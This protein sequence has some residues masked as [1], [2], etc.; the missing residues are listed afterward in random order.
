[1][2][3]EDVETHVNTLFHDFPPDIKSIYLNLERQV[4]AALNGQDEHKPETIQAPPPPRSPSPPALQ[5]KK[6]K[7]KKKIPKDK[8]FLTPKLNVEFTVKTAPNHFDTTVLDR[9][10]K[11]PANISVPD[12]ALPQMTPPAAGW[13]APESE[14]VLTRIKSVRPKSALVHDQERLPPIQ[15]LEKEPEPSDLRPIKSQ[16]ISHRQKETPTERQ[17]ELSSVRE[18]RKARPK[19]A[20]VRHEQMEPKKKRPL[21]A[22]PKKRPVNTIDVEQFKHMPLEHFDDAQK[23]ETRS[24]EEWVRL[25]PSRGERGTPGSSRYHSVGNNPQEWKWAPCLVLDYDTNDH[26][27]LIEWPDGHQKHVTRFNLM[28]DEEDKNRYF[29]RIEA[30]NRTKAELIA[31]I[32]HE[33]TVLSREMV[34]EG[35][36]ADLEEMYDYSMKK[37]DYMLQQKKLDEPKRDPYMNIFMEQLQKPGSPVKVDEAIY[38][39]VIDSVREISTFLFTANGNLQTALFQVMGC[40]NAILP[41]EKQFF[42]SSF[43]R[44]IFFVDFMQRMTVDVETVQNIVTKLLSDFFDFEQSDYKQYNDS[45][46]QKFL[47]LLNAVMIAQTQ[48]MVEDA[49]VHFLGMFQIGVQKLENNNRASAQRFKLTEP[50]LR[51]I[52][53]ES[54][55]MI[56]ITLFDGKAEVQGSNDEIAQKLHIRGSNQI[57]IFPSIKKVTEDIKSLFGKPWRLTE[58]S[59]PHIESL[60]ME[61]LEQALELCLP[62]N[63]M[64]LYENGSRLIE[65]IIKAATPQIEAVFERYKR[66]EFIVKNDPL[67]V[68]NE[69]SLLEEFDGPVKLIHNARKAIQDISDNHVPFPPFVLDCSVIK[70]VYMTLTSSALSKIG[71]LLAK[72][73]ATAC[74]QMLSVYDDL[75]EKLRFDPGVNVDKWE[76]LEL[77]LMNSVIEFDTFNEQF[78][79]IQN[80]WQLMFDY[81]MPVPSEVDKLYWRTFKWPSWFA[82]EQDQSRKRLEASRTMITN[83]FGEDIKQI[84][85]LISKVKTSLDDLSLITDLSHEPIVSENLVPLAKMVTKVKDL[86]VNVR[87]ASKAMHMEMPVFEGLDDL[88]DTFPGY[89]MLW[90]LVKDTQRSLAQWIQEPFMEINAELIMEKLSVWN[91]EISTLSRSFE[92]T[93]GPRK[94]LA[95]LR[96]HVH[97]FSLNTKVITY[98]RS[99]A[100]RDR[101]WEKIQVVTGLTLNDFVGLRLHQILHLD[102]E[103]ISDILKDISKQAEREYA[104]EKLMEQ[105]KQDLVQK[106]FV[107]S[108]TLCSSYVAIQNGEFCLQ[109]IEDHII[110]AEQFYKKAEESDMKQKYDQWIGQLNKGYDLVRRWMQLQTVF[111]QLYPVFLNES[112]WPLLGQD[113]VD[114][115]QSIEKSMSV[116]SNVLTKNKKFITV[117]HRSDLIEL[118]KGSSTRMDRLVDRTKSLLTAKRDSYPRLYFLNDEKVLEIVSS[119]T[120]AQ[121]S[122]HISLIFEHVASLIEVSLEDNVNGINRIRGTLERGLSSMQSKKTEEPIRRK[123]AEEKKRKN[124]SAKKERRPSSSMDGSYSD[125]PSRRSSRRGSSFSLGR[126][127]LAVSATDTETDDSSG[128]PSV[129]ERRLS[130]KF[131]AG[132]LERKTSAP[133]VSAVGSDY[134]TGYQ[135]DSSKNSSFKGMN[136]RWSKV[137]G[138]SFMLKRGIGPQKTSEERKKEEDE[139]HP[140]QE[141]DARLAYVGRE[142]R[143]MEGDSFSFQINYPIGA[144]VELLFKAIQDEIKSTLWDLCRRCCTQFPRES[145]YNTVLKC[146]K[147]FNLQIGMIAAHVRWVEEM[148]IACASGPSAVKQCKSK[149]L[150][151][152]DALIAFTKTSITMSVRHKME[153]LISHLNTLIDMLLGDHEHPTIVKYRFDDESGIFVSMEGTRSFKYGFEY[154]GSEARISLTPS[155]NAIMY[156]LF[157][158]ST[159]THLPLLQGAQ[160]SGKTMAAQEMAYVCGMQIYIIHCSAEFDLVRVQN[161]LRGFFGSKCWSYFGS[162]DTLAKP[163]LTELI[164]HLLSF[165]SIL[166]KSLTNETP[167]IK[168]HT[169]VFELDKNM[170]A[171]TSTFDPKWRPSKQTRDQYRVVYI[172]K[173]DIEYQ[174]RLML[175]KSGFKHDY[176]LARRIVVFFRS[177]SSALPNEFEITM[178]RL[179][180]I[181]EQAIS[182]K[183][184]VTS[185]YACI[186]TSIMRHM[187]SSFTLE[188]GQLF[189]NMLRDIFKTG[190]DTLEQHSREDAL[191][192]ASKAFPIVFNDYFCKRA[193]HFMDCINAEGNLIVYGEP[194]VG[195]STLTKL[196][197]QAMQN[198]LPEETFVRC[199]RL[200]PFS[201][202]IV[203][204]IRATGSVRIDEGILPTLLKSLSRHCQQMESLSRDFGAFYSFGWLVF[205][206]RLQ[207]EWMDYTSS[208]SQAGMAFNGLVLPK[209]LKFVYEASD[210]SEISPSS[211]AN[212]SLIYLEAEKI[213]AQVVFS[214]LSNHADDLVHNHSDFFEDFLKIVLMPAIRFYEQLNE[215]DQKVILKRIW[216]LF[217]CLIQELGNSGYERLTKQEQYV[218]ISSQLLFSL[219][220][221]Y[222]AVSSF[223]KRLKFSQYLMGSLESQL[224]VLESK[225]ELKRQLLVNAL[226]FPDTGT[227]F[228]Y[229]FDHKTLVW[230]KW[231]PFSH[232]TVVY[233]KETFVMTQDMIRFKYL[234]K[235]LLKNDKHVVF[236]SKTGYGKSIAAKCTL[237]S[238]RQQLKI[239][240][241]YE[242]YCTGDEEQEELRQLFETKFG[243][244]KRF[245]TFGTGKGQNN[246]FLIED[247]GAF[248]VNGQERNLEMMRMLLDTRTYYASN[249]QLCRMEDSQFVL[250]QDSSL[251]LPS[252]IGYHFTELNLDDNLQRVKEI[253]FRDVQQL[254]ADV[255]L[256]MTHTAL[257]FACKVYQQLQ[258]TYPPNP[259]NLFTLRDLVRVLK[260]LVNESD[261]TAVPAVFDCLG[262]SLSRVFGDRLENKQ[263][264]LDYL[265]KEFSDS[266]QHTLKPQIF[267]QPLIVLRDETLDLTGGPLEDVD[268]L[269]SVIQHRKQWLS[270]IQ[271][272]WHIAPQS[273]I[274]EASKLAFLVK[275]CHS[276]LLVTDCQ[277]FSVVQLG[278]FMAQFDCLLFDMTEPWD[279][280]IKNCYTK[281]FKNQETVV[282]YVEFEWLDRFMKQDLND[283]YLT[284]MIA[285]FNNLM[286]DIDFKAVVDAFMDQ[287][288]T[289]REDLGSKVKEMAR[290]CIS[291]DNNHIPMGNFLA[292][293]PTFASGLQL[294]HRD[295]LDLVSIENLLSFSLLS[296]AYLSATEINSVS[297]FMHDV[298]RHFD[299]LIQHE[300]SIH[301]SHQHHRYCIFTCIQLFTELYLKHKTQLVTDFDL[302][303]VSIQNLLQE[304][305]KDR[306]MME[307]GHRDMKREK[308]MLRKYEDEVKILLEACSVE[309]ERVKP[310][311]GLAINGVSALQRGDIYD[312]KGLTKSVEGIELVMQA[313]LLLL[314]FELLPN[315]LAMISDPRFQ[316]N[317]AEFDVDSPVVAT[318]H[319]LDIITHSDAFNVP[320][321]PLKAAMALREWVLAVHKYQTTLISLQHKRRI[322][323]ETELKAEARKRQIETIMRQIQNYQENIK[324][325]KAQFEVMMKQ[326]EEVRLKQKKFKTQSES[327]NLLVTTVLKLESVFAEDRE[328]TAKKIQELVSQCLMTALISGFLGSFSKRT[329]EWAVKEWL[330]KLE[331]FGLSSISGHFWIGELL[332]K[333]S[334]EDTCFNLNL[335]PDLGLLE[336]AMIAKSMLKPVLLFDSKRELEP[337]IKALESESGKLVLYQSHDPDLHKKLLEAKQKG[338]RCIIYIE[339]LNLPKT[340]ESS[341]T[342]FSP[343]VPSVYKI[344]DRQSEFKLYLVLPFHPKH[345]ASTRWMQFTQPIVLSSCDRAMQLLLIE[346]ISRKIDPQLASQ[347]FQSQSD[348][349]HLN[350]TIQKLRAKAVSFVTM[351]EIQNFYGGDIYRN[352]VDVEQ[353]LHGVFGTLGMWNESNALLLDLRATYSSVS[354]VATSLYMLCIQIE[355]V[356]QRHLFSKNWF[357][358]KC[359]T[360]CE[361]IKTL[362]NQAIKQFLEQLIHAIVD[363]FGYS[364]DMSCRLAFYYLLSQHLLEYAIYERDKTEKMTI[365]Q[366]R[367][368][369]NAFEPEKKSIDNTPNPAHLW[370]NEDGW[371]SLQKLSR[372][373]EFTKLYLDFSNWEEVAKAVEPQKRKF[374]AKWNHVLSNSQKILVLKCLRPD[375]VSSFIDDYVQAI[376]GF[377]LDYPPHIYEQRLMKSD[378]KTPVLVYSNNLEETG[379]FVR[380]FS[381]HGRAFKSIVISDNHELTQAIH[382][383]NTSLKDGVWLILVNRSLDLHKLLHVEEQIQLMHASNGVHEEFRLWIITDKNP[384]PQTW[385]LESI[386]ITNSMQFEDF[387]ALFYTVFQILRDNVAPQEFR[388]TGAYRR[389]L[390][391][392]CHFYCVMRFREYTYPLIPESKTSLQLNDLKLAIQTMRKE[393]TIHVSIDPDD[394]SFIPRLEH[395]IFEKAFSGR[396]LSERDLQWAK[397]MFRTLLDC[398]WQVSF[399]ESKP[400]SFVHHCFNAMI[401]GDL[402]AAMEIIRSAPRHAD[403]DYSTI[404]FGPNYKCIRDSFLTKQFQDS[405]S[406]LLPDLS[407]QSTK[408]DNPLELGKQK[409][410][411]LVQKLENAIKR[412]PFRKEVKIEE[413][414]SMDSVM[415]PQKSYMDLLF[416]ENVNFYLSFVNQLLLDL[417]DIVQSSETFF[418]TKR[419]HQLLDQISKNTTPHEFSNYEHPYDWGF[420]D[421]DK[422]SLDLLARLN[423]ME[424]WHQHRI[425]GGRNIYIHDIQKIHSPKALIEAVVLDFAVHQREHVENVELE[426]VAM[427]N[428]VTGNETVVCVS[429]LVLVGASF[430]MHKSYLKEARPYEKYTLLP[431]VEWLMIDYIAAVCA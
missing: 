212:H 198:E 257:G 31:E 64:E 216:T 422:W 311:L 95:A 300:R 109:V 250:V 306:E 81:G 229:V 238:I 56:K 413:S 385:I 386:R 135:S 215:R 213:N 186:G 265:K 318:L 360:Y 419:S 120:A 176:A 335:S 285:G 2:N 316:T 16:E 202:D 245:N 19:T 382:T 247:V 293:Y 27:Y 425:K 54:F 232:Q 173:P 217:D 361:E 350:N 39:K 131:I 364:L 192:E 69:D 152:V 116:L 25:G 358:E 389:S 125:N 59:I 47:S 325:K 181:I 105:M 122:Q 312:L 22:V 100:L 280:F 406:L 348:K 241:L 113:A 72:K 149:F 138:L 421:F 396:F 163:V 344:V 110:S 74:N 308:E 261:R 21:T 220:W 397:E 144:R 429:G 111:L 115:F 4:R 140:E 44:P 71:K 402:S 185:E 188:E 303:D 51:Q 371:K 288:K 203:N 401:K 179:K 43:T 281:I 8:P 329:R 278:S 390:F 292:S 359:K 331:S 370:L 414:K 387:R 423:Y 205:D 83:R 234:L 49:L 291:M 158:T 355:T 226:A 94:I 242:V 165:C 244:K 99:A 210:I 326:K 153:Q 194:L 162:V 270:K 36:L 276:H 168:F 103:L 334:F 328:Q 50:Y 410:A 67:R 92:T 374:P 417:K 395:L 37:A 383:L 254:F 404:E 84:N 128:K 41:A 346:S 405:L 319:A 189:F 398:T 170:S 279:Q 337:Y 143:S 159:E 367:F 169:T 52:P 121:L 299:Q 145:T 294:F 225:H 243:T 199:E 146:F 345:I 218:W 354:Q 106:E 154:F 182:L 96:T 313:V 112:L 394:E 127:S 253:M 85:T 224:A 400:E 187:K 427:Q 157:E 424:S 372:L 126:P 289:K 248:S 305:D 393:F 60:L 295:E 267:V 133:K 321:L 88:L 416:G 408:R 40:I 230:R 26:L 148:E 336:S 20:V 101:H 68:L 14:N 108:P 76:E 418:L 150:D 269:V 48:T 376:F 46:L 32:Q 323:T 7:K 184:Q 208:I 268:E 307:D 273:A 274:L 195:K 365:Q 196:C 13:R 130:A 368:L 137:K 399:E 339:D 164:D 366:T 277:I 34:S 342:F 33:N 362:D 118:V 55:L 191:F 147:S 141:S 70:F 6:K 63:D 330:L 214:G 431:N 352:I 78:K 349:Q 91:E 10:I 53:L 332:S 239:L 251:K 222:G 369:L 290:I 353:N 262:H 204:F 338:L 380:D 65:N 333:Y 172:K 77:S 219:I 317:V 193:V 228:D 391:N 87:K 124:S 246:I 363:Y 17:T 260:I 384:I 38:G 340:L 190:V 430:D 151:I 117:I 375:S 381:R 29:A 114:S 388:A 15:S 160:G 30:A 327:I 341:I 378:S 155:L 259:T 102:L 80:T 93:D 235:V 221:E 175:N 23:Y 66:F 315:E 58:K 167:T 28:F 287:T 42:R 18:T 3:P 320:V 1:M 377:K 206:G 79:S 123:S 252:S 322:A 275:N 45:R 296:D 142:I 302:I 282:I 211:L 75:N 428:K 119:R 82:G 343:P 426:I 298:L 324:A 136:T 407:H 403:L 35:F 89:E 357:V 24:P 139:D 174:L 271:N 301:I 411:Q 351:M 180:P 97:D 283:F 356:D 57:I 104:A 223:D 420:H 183:K 227:V 209:S 373:P 90:K 272:L 231:A 73:I 347:V 266:L 255:G 132:D 309:I 310:G 171:F 61:K 236:T 197:Q 258:I 249:N 240:Q 264:F 409:I 62:T 304:M 129:R 166:Q 156:H 415:D 161:A 314:K 284:G 5:T 392:L 177:L 86:H 297:R 379:V 286:T 233:Q 256:D 98:L 201:M 12:L 134:P 263:E 107:L 200:Y 178:H 412:K 9:L 207:K 237:H 11:K